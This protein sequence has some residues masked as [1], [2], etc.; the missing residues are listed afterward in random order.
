MSNSFIFSERFTDDNVIG[1]MVNMIC[2][3]MALLLAA[4]VM[5]LCNLFNILMPMLIYFGEVCKQLSF[6]VWFHKDIT[7]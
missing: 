7:I 4:T 5:Y 2:I 3:F 1:T 6:N